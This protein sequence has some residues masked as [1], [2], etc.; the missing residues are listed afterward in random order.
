M[1]GNTPNFNKYDILRCFLAV[2]KGISRNRLKKELGIGEG[3]ARSILDTLKK[4]GLISS[5]RKGHS[6]TEK[7]KGIS[8]KL[9]NIIELKKIRTDIYRGTKQAAALIKHKKPAKIEVKLRD[10]AIK[11]GADA[12]LILSFDKKLHAPGIEAGFPELDN[13]FGFEKNNILVVSFA[14][15]QRDAENS[16]L[17]VADEISSDLG[18]LL[19]RQS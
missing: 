9:S 1:V 14:K 6:L 19:L 2:G 4:K 7:G 8:A 18:R 16:A 15:T 3:T 10:T 5:T 13:L 11:N 12:A 17:A